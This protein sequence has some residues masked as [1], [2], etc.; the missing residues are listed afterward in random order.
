MSLNLTK[1]EQACKKAG[2]KCTAQRKL[3]YTELLNRK[4]HPDA[5]TL[6]QSVRKTNRKISLDTVYRTLWLLK[7]MGLISVLGPTRERTRFDGNLEMHHHF[8]C[9]QCGITLDFNNESFN[10]LNIP[11]HLEHIGIA[12][13]L[14]VQVHGICIECS[15]VNLQAKSRS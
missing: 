1:L 11:D 10:R 2:V 9:D 15:R 12:K 13:A 8:I 6:Y 7:E 4:D 14:Q 5:E 3:I